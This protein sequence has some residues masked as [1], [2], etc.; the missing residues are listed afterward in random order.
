MIEPTILVVDPSEGEREDTVMALGEGLPD[1]NIL[2]AYS[3]QQALERL[4]NQSVDTVVTRYHL[5]GGS[6][7]EL[8]AEIRE[9]YPETDCYVY[10]ETT[11]I[12]TESFEETVVEFVPKGTPDSVSML[13]A[14]VEQAE[15]EVGQLSYPV[16]DNEQERLSVLDSYPMEDGRLRTAFD[17]IVELATAH[18]EVSAASLTVVDERTQRS[19]AETGSISIPVERDCAL[20]THTL[21]SENS[22]MAIEDVREDP[23]FV[24]HPI[25]GTAIRSYLGAKT[26][27]PNGHAIGSLNLYSDAP[28]SFSSADQAYLGA[29]ASLVVDILEMTS[30]ST[31]E[32]LERLTEGES[33]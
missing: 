4:E 9:Q 22:V 18:F 30:D 27:T 3:Y 15:S 24:D 7:L 23:R 6:G 26:E 29:L 21:V 25:Q 16:P 32:S 12:D 2:T 20:S 31:T 33:A 13:T 5:E 10:A 17:R 11:E 14:L 8:T 28:R 1:A 19:I